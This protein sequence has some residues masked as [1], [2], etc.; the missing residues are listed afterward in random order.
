M[1]IKFLASALIA[2]LLMTGTVSPVSPASGQGVQSTQATVTEATPL[3]ETQATAIALEHAKLTEADVTELRVRLDRDD[4]RQHWE[5][6]FRS[7][8]W[9]YEYDIDLATGAVWEWDRDYEPLRRAAPKPTEPKPTEPKPTEPKPTEPAREEKTYLSAD[10]AKA[11]AL[12]H[13]DLTAD[14]VKGLR[15]EFDRDDRVPVY[16][17]EFRSGRYEYDYEIHAE[18]GKVLDFDKDTDD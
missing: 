12:K 4:R 10:Q 14:Q 2:A 5:I 1:P 17:V 3:T 13:A 18:T 9:E 6:H 8:D 16:E 15:A 7:G 11:I